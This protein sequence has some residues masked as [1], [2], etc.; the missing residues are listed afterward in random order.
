M[1]PAKGAVFDFEPGRAHREIDRRVI[2]HVEKQHLR[3]GGDQRPFEMGDLAR[4]P[5]LKQLAQR[6]ANRAK[7]PQRDGHDRA[8]ESDV[9]R[10][11]AAKPGRDRARRKTLF[12]RMGFADDVA[13]NGGGGETRGKPRMM[14]GLQSCG[15]RGAAL[16]RPIERTVAVP[17]SVGPARR[18]VQIH[19]LLGA[20]TIKKGGFRSKSL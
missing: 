10:V 3:R 8:G 12:E 16:P 18:G 14:L 7:P 9:A 17:W 19:A 4:Q 5:F 20:S 6:R 2:R 1:S 11:E 15:F 13:Q